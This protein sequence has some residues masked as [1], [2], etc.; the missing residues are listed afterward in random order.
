MVLSLE[1]RMLIRII[2]ERGAEGGREGGREVSE[3]LM[4]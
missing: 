2:C 4:K 1:G 3:G